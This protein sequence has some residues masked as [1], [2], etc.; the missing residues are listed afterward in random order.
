MPPTVG[1]EKAEK[2]MT[3][4]DRT[5]TGLKSI[6]FKIRKACNKD[7]ANSL[8]GP[9]LEKIDSKTPIT[10]SVDEERRNERAA[11]KAAKKAAEKEMVAAQKAKAKREKRL[12]ERYTL[13]N[14]DVSWDDVRPIIQKRRVDDLAFAEKW[15]AAHARK[16]ADR[17][18]WGMMDN[19][20]RRYG[21]REW[22]FVDREP[23]VRLVGAEGL[24]W[25]GAAGEDEDEDE[26]GGI[27][28]DKDEGVDEGEGV[29]EGE[30]AHEDVHEY[31]YDGANEYEHEDEDEWLEEW[32]MDAVSVREMV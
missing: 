24:N 27:N 18:L 5:T 26:G 21:V 20:E 12:V 1:R 13:G 30:G 23:W 3:I 7:K 6:G 2:T 29:L 22:H 28:Q 31:E 14:H 16:A 11:E 4:M 19:V 32:G 9:D 10:F 17:E 8:K 25:S 15:R